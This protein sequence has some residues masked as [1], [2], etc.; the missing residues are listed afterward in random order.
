[1]PDTRAIVWNQLILAAALTRAALAHPG[2][3]QDDPESVPFCYTDT[4]AGSGR[5][6]PPRPWL[7]Q[8]LA[9]RS[10]FATKAFFAALEGDGHPG[11]W[12]LAG[13]V[14]AAARPDL[15]ID[16]DVNDIDPH[17][18]ALARTHREQAR[19]RF[20]SHDWFLFLRSR[21]AMPGRPDF[22]FI[23]PPLDDARGPAYAIDAAILLDTLNVPYM[24][25]YPLRASQDPIDQ[26]GRTGLELE[27]ASGGCG[28]LLGGGAE[29]VVLDLM[30]D[31]R[32]LA[33]VLDGTFAAR[34]PRNDDYSI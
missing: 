9:R 6:T 16:I 1:M 29:T 30:A 23:D 11:S 22:V 27:L 26:I 18:L 19:V 12:V 14:L 17:V 25:T 13:R 5:L 10:E 8:V 2:G 3:G 7:D 24:V 21:L 15:A 32:R 28:A 31:L 33:T 4:H 20:W 34:L